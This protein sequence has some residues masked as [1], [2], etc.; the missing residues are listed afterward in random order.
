MRVSTRICSTLLTQSKTSGRIS[1]LLTLGAGVDQELTGRDNIYLQGAFLGLGKKEIDRKIG[2]IID[3]S[4]LDKFV[5]VPLRQYSAGM[6]QRL[7]FSVA[8]NIE[9][10]ILLIDEVLEV[11]DAAFRQKCRVRM[12]ELI[13]KA[14]AILLVSHSMETVQQLCNKAL[15]LHQGETLALGTSREVVSSYLAA[16]KTLGT[17]NP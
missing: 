5:D 17:T 6:I 4:E 16:M 9:P 2:D 8:V 3:F 7:S 1:T 15:W 10:D 14:R 13:G 11:G 12:K